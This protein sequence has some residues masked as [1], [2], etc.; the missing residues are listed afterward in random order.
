[1]NLAQPLDFPLL[2]FERVANAKSN[3][4]AKQINVQSRQGEGLTLRLSAFLFVFVLK[5]LQSSV[6]GSDDQNTH[7][8]KELCH[9]SFFFP[10]LS[11]EASFTVSRLQEQQFCPV[12]LVTSGCS[13]LGSF[14]A[15]ATTALVLRK[16]SGAPAFCYLPSISLWRVQNAVALCP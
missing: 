6:F 4:S 9:S 5:E 16:R 3:Q 15:A 2:L 10:L 12:T 11:L 1:M 13:I 8:L 14:S 7:A